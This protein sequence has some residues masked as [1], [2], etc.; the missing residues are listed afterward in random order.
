LNKDEIE[1]FK[2]FDLF[3]GIEYTQKDGVIEIPIYIKGFA[4][5]FMTKHPH[6][7]L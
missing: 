7:D 3:T 2:Y 5:L 1:N 4:T 6:A